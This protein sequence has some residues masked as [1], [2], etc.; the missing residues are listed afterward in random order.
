[1]TQDSDRAKRIAALNDQFRKDP[2]R[3]GKAFTTDGVASLGFDLVRQA[4]AVVAAF[5]AFTAGNDPYG[6]HDFGSFDLD[7]EKLC[8]KIDYYDS[9]DPDLGAA[10]AGNPA[11]TE[12]VLTLMLASEY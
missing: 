10:D 9:A 3:L 7:G 5:D 12:R 8:W 4:M 1:M 6:E 11:T 2:R